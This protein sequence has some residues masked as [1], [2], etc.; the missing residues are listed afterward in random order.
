MNGLGGRVEGAGVRIVLH[1]AAGLGWA[2]LGWEELNIENK[3]R[4]NDK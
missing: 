2:G 4:D 3:T 1:H